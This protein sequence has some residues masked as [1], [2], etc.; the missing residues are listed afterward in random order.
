MPEALHRWTREEVLALPDDT[1]PEVL[2]DRI[3]WQPDS[4]LEPLTIV[5]D[6]IFGED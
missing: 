4:A 5:L 2:L 3:T 6:T 1:R